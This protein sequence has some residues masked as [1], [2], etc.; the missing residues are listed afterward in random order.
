M[1]SKHN[2]HVVATAENFPFL[3]ITACFIG[4]Y[5]F[6]SRPCAGSRGNSTRVLRGFVA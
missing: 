2:V 3:S 5:A 1:D 6:G 4:R